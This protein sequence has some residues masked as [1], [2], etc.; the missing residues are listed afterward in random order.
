MLVNSFGWDEAGEPRIVFAEFSLVPASN[1][2]KHTQSLEDLQCTPKNY[3]WKPVSLYTPIVNILKNEKL[4]M[5]Q[6]FSKVTE[7]ILNP[8][9][10]CFLAQVFLLFFFLSEEAIAWWKHANII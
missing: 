5:S 7:L 10:V 8:Q 9:N 1:P 3:I 4:R 6:N 2:Y